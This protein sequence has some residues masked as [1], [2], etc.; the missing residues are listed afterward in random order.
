MKAWTMFLSLFVVCLVAA[1]APA[2]GTASK[3]LPLFERFEK[4]DT[5]HDGIVTAQEFAAAHPK[6]GAKAIIFYNQL[7]ALGGTTTKG[8]VVGM[9]LPQFKKALKAWKQAHPNQGGKQ[10]GTN[11]TN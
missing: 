6:L 8:G 4:M 7:A 1:N 9:T 5:N 10:Q 11:Y 2:Q 3:R